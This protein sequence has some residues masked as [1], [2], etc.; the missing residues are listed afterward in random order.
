MG[1]LPAGLVF[2]DRRSSTDLN[3]LE[4]GDRRPLA[5]TFQPALVIVDP[6]TDVL[7]DDIHIAKEHANRAL[8][9]IPV[10]TAGEGVSVPE[11]RETV[12]RGYEGSLSPR[13]W[14]R[15][16]PSQSVRRVRRCR[17]M[18][19]RTHTESSEEASA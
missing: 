16:M 13:S 11:K 5:F 1:F 3:V 15:Y 17:A 6:Q 18:S 19:N 9:V 8:V 10:L 12:L 7:G 4:R 2:L 14:I